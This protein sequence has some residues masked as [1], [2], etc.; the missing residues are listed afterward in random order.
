MVYGFKSVA[1][2][3]YRSINDVIQELGGLRSRLD[4]TVFKG[5]DK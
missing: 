4:P 1:I 3:W 2:P 5:K